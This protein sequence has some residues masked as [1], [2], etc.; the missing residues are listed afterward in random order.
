VSNEPAGLAL[1]LSL[2]ALAVGV[3]GVVLGYRAGR[4]TVS[5]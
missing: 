1:F 5:S 3:A 2:L 4:R